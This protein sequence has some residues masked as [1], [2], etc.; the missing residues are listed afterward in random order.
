MERSSL[1]VTSS[2]LLH[3][4][5]IRRGL[6]HQLRERD[7]AGGDEDEDRDVGKEFKFGESKGG[8][9]KGNSDGGGDGGSG[10]EENGEESKDGKGNADESAVDPSLGKIV[11]GYSHCDPENHR[12]NIYRLNK[13][14]ALRSKLGPSCSIPGRI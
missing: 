13:E 2:P 5:P 14:M 1:C 3:H 4:V 11:E 9:H 7:V 12:N 8:R 6:Y 10:N